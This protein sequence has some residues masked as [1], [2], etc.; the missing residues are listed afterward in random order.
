[1]SM[2]LITNFEA[3]AGAE[4]MLARYLAHSPEQGAELVSLRQISAV[5]RTLV[6][7]GDVTFRSL[8]ARSPAGLAGAIA[9]LAGR[10]RAAPP[11]RLVCWMYHAM[12]VGSLAVCASGRRIPTFWMVRQSLDDP[13]SLSRSSRLAILAA[14]RL[15][16]R[17]DGILYNSERARGLHRRRGFSARNDAMIPNGFLMPEIVPARDRSPQVFGIAARVHPQKD[18]VTFLAAAARVARSLPEARFVLAGRGTEA[19]APKIERLIAE[20]GIGRD[21]L[22]LR[23]EL[24]D[25]SSFYQEIDALVLSSRTEGFPN[26]VGEAMSWGRPVVTTDV[27]DAAAVVGDAGRVVPAGDPDALAAAMEDFARIAPE[28]WAALGR[29]ARERVEARYGIDA[30][31]ARIAAFVGERKAP[32][33]AAEAAVY[34]PASPSRAR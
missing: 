24:P 10:F 8:G 30:V 29:A 3:R 7:N 22:S 11:D 5:N 14:A 18:H 13:A 15:S 23:G 4:S 27:G 21:R 9:R 34:R 6:G 32:D 1:M 12:V 19:G 16:G 33:P 20:S 31:C 17:A 2:H 25:L 26:V 28:A